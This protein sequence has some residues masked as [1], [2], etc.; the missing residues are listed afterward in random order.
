MLLALNPLLT[1]ALT[2]AF[3]RFAGLDW[4]WSLLLAAAAAVFDALRSCFNYAEQHRSRWIKKPNP[5]T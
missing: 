1:F 5:S 2:L 4:T 3:L